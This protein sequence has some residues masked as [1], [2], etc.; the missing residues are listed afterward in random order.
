MPPA[1]THALHNLCFT[2]LVELQ[3]LVHSHRH[4]RTVRRELLELLQQH[5]HMPIIAR[6]I[7][8]YYIKHS[9]CNSNVSRFE[10]SGPGPC[11][12]QCMHRCQY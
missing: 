6:L 11:A 2:I 12:V 4:A 5:L 1:R 3:E 8:S 10:A 9:E 7:K